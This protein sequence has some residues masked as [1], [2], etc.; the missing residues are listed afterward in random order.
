MKLI[1]IPRHYGSTGGSQ[2]FLITR[3]H[4]AIRY[5]FHNSFE[6]VINSFREETNRSV[7]IYFENTGVSLPLKSCL[8]QPNAPKSNKV[9]RFSLPNYDDM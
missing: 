8:K 1:S 2:P 5:R 4:N 9:V 7:N 3:P 6:D